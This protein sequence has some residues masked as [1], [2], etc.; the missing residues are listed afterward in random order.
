VIAG[1][2]DEFERREFCDVLR[3]LTK[4][5]DVKANFPYSALALLEFSEPVDAV[6]FAMH[7][8]LNRFLSESMDEE[9][10]LVYN[11][12]LA[13]SYSKCMDLRDKL[14][15]R[16]YVV[17]ARVPFS[18]VRPWLITRHRLT[19]IEILHDNGISLD[20][21]IIVWTSIGESFYAVIGAYALRNMG[22]IVFPQ[23][24]YTTIEFMTGVPDL[25][26]VKLGKLQNDLRDVGVM[27][28][29]AISIEFELCGMFKPRKNVKHEPIDEE[30]AAVVEVKGASHLGGRGHSQLDSY[31]SSMLFDYGILICPGR[32]DDPEYYPRHGVVT[33]RDSE[34]L[35]SLPKNISEADPARKTL[36]IN[37][38]K[39][40]ILTKILSW[41]KM[42][43]LA[44]IGELSLAEIIEE[45]IHGNIDIKRLV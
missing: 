27:E 40:Y 45:I 43:K 23:E 9:F 4:V 18:G 44:N 38:T 29:G 16:R 26:A 1:S 3:S 42:S 28:F 11:P 30:L 39:R 41:V 31:L 17:I 35:V 6:T 10:K 19:A 36:L 37:S 15:N 32:I 13:Y 34:C 5:L 24:S 2:P 7:F 12:G 8:Q 25:I 20:E 33:W 22:F 21:A 14:I